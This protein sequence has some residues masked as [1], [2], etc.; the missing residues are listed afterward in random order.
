MTVMKQSN[1]FTINYLSSGRKVLNE[2]IARG[3]G[4]LKLDL[5]SAALGL[6]GSYYLSAGNSL[7]AQVLFC[8]ANPILAGLAWKNKSYPSV[9]LFTAYEY[10]AAVGVLKLLGVI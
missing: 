9:L 4:L 7:I 5:L 2:I 1:S 6:T 8:L 3:K 10:F